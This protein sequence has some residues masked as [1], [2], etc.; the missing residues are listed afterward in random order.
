MSIT[1][2]E[3][4][5]V[6]KHATLNGVSKPSTSVLSILFQYVPVGRIRNSSIGSLYF[7]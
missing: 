2:S 5:P 3:T 1:E 7:V 6:G 4:L